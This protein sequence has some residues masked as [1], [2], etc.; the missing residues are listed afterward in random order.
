MQVKM[1]LD[2]LQQALPA[3]GMGTEQ[4]KDVL[5]AVQRLSRHMPQGVPTAGVQQTS[6]QDMIKNGKRNALLQMLMAQ[7]GGGQ[8]Q[9]GQPPPPSTP[10]PGA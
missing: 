7:L 5:Q 3:L 4:H 6:M 10:L 8:Q 2:M 9:G 1:A